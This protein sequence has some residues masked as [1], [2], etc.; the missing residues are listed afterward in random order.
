ASVEFSAT[1]ASTTVHALL[2]VSMVCRRSSFKSTKLVLLPARSNLKA[3]LSAR[4]AACTVPFPRHASPVPTRGQVSLLAVKASCTSVGQTSLLLAGTWS[5]VVV[6]AGAGVPCAGGAAVR[7]GAGCAVD[8]ASSVA[9]VMG[10][11][12]WSTG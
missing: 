11:A 4:G 9:I 10:V 5:V 1:C 8:R 12:P 7:P 3:E 6:A 2:L